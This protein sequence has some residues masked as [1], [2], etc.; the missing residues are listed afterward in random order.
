VANQVK[1]RSLSR[2]L[3]WGNTGQNLVRE[4]NT[5]TENLAIHHEKNLEA[6]CIV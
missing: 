3:K 1:N 4:D 2:F 5:A 6:M